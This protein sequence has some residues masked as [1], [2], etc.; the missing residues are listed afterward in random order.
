MRQLPYRYSNRDNDLNLYYNSKIYEINLTQYLLAFY[1]FL[2]QFL[3]QF[4]W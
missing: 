3:L 4:G 1:S 2:F